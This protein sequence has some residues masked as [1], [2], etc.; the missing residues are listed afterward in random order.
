MHDIEDEPGLVGHIHAPIFV[1]PDFSG[2]LFQEFADK[3]SNLDPQIRQ[4]LA[5]NIQRFPDGAL[6]AELYAVFSHDGKARAELSGSA[7]G[8]ARPP[9]VYVPKERRGCQSTKPNVRNGSIA[10]AAG[11]VDSSLC[12]ARCCIV[13][14]REIGGR[15]W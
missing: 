5:L 14:R 2:V 15:P 8:A 12:L 10:D 3:S 9:W 6:R 7:P 13:C 1:D 4:G 11:L